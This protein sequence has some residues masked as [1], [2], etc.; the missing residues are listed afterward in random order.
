MIAYAIGRIG[1]QV[2]G[3]GDWGIYNSA[4]KVDSTNNIV[5]QRPN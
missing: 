5:L 1:C 4:Y 2:A 3:D